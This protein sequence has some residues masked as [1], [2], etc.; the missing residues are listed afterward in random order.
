MTEIDRIQDQLRRAF[1]GSAWHGPSV[2]EVLNGISAKQAAARPIVGAHS[3]WELVLHIIAWE[4]AGRRR[5]AGDRAQLA[6]EEDWPP[7]TDTSETAWNVSRI[8]LEQ[9]HEELR[10]EISHLRESRLD[11]PI[12]EGMSSVYVTLHG[13][14]QHDLYHAG[15][16]AILKKAV[17]EVK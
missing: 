1:E 2:Q 11:Q 13:V 5:L 3:I 7:V 10:R 4:G 15:Q 6:D 14:I 16:I 17:A 8:E 9:G 12:L